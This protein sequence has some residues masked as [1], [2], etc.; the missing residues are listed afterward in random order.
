MENNINSDRHFDKQGYIKYDDNDYNEEIW[1]KNNYY[2][3]VRD[4]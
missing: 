3:R 4:E 2:S 1:K